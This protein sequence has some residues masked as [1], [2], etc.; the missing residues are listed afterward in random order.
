MTG[1]VAGQLSIQEILRKR[2][3]ETLSLESL[4]L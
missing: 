1:P 4:L 2:K 3:A